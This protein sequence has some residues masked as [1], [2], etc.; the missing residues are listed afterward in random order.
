MK[1]IY[2]TILFVLISM[3]LSISFAVAQTPAKPSKKL[4]YLQSDGY[5]KALKY[6]ATENK[7]VLLFFNSH[8]CHQ[9]EKFSSEVMESDTF[10]KAIKGKFIAVNASV[11][12]DDAKKAAIKFGVMKLPLLV[13][14][15]SAMPEFFYI[16]EMTMNADSMGKQADA[17]TAAKNLYDQILLMTST[18]KISN[19]SASA[20]IARNYAKRDYTKYKDNEATLHCKSR[21]LDIKFFTKFKDIYIQEWEIQKKKAAAKK[22]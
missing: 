11:N 2:N 10:I 3:V 14:M 22:P 17:F 15:H 12:N 6:A 1:H 5:A 4:N 16:C 13:M 18:N 20:E 7:P 8:D 21:T 9:C 19:D